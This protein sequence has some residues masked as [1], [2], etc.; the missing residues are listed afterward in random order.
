[1]DQS[2]DAPMNGMLTGSEGGHAAGQVTIDLGM[3]SK[4]VLTLSGIN[5]DKVPDGHVYRTK[6]ADHMHGV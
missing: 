6:A 3:G 1:M 5:I 4:S 2:M